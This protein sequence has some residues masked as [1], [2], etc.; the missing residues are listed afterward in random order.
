MSGSKS[1]EGLVGML[2]V[3]MDDVISKGV[4]AFFSRQEPE[5]IEF[6]KYDNGYQI[7]VFTDGENAKEARDFWEENVHGKI[8]EEI[9]E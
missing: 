1:L 7:Q 8:Q 4:A 2:P 5:S 3:D 9:E 6:T